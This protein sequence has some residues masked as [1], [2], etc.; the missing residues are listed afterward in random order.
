MNARVITGIALLVVTRL[1]GAQCPPPHLNPQDT[2]ATARITYRAVSTS[3]VVG[4]P[5]VGASNAS[6]VVGNAGEPALTTHVPDHIVDLRLGYDDQRS[7][8]VTSA[9]R[10]PQSRDAIAIGGYGRVRSMHMIR[11]GLVADDGGCRQFVAS[12]DNRVSGHPIVD[13]QSAGSV[14]QG[15]TVRSEDDLRRLGTVSRLADGRLHVRSVVQDRARPDDLQG[16]IL[17][18]YRRSGRSF[19]I[20]RAEIA[21]ESRAIREDG[22]VAVLRNSSIHEFDGV[23]VVIPDS[24]AEHRRLTAAIPQRSLILTAPVS[25]APDVR[26]L[27]RDASQPGAFLPSQNDGGSQNVVFQH[28][29]LANG[30]TWARME[31]WL[32]GDFAFG[33]KLLPSLRSTDRLGAQRDALVQRITE[34]GARDWILIGHSNGGLVSRSAAQQIPGLVRGVITSSSLHNGAI[35]V[36][37]GRE[38][39]ARRL[40]EL[41]GTLGNLAAVLQMPLLGG[42]LSSFAFDSLLPVTRDMSPSSAFIRQLNASDE[43]FLR[44]SI[45]NISD[46]RWVAFRVVGDSR[47][48][49]ESGCGGRAWVRYVNSIYMAL[50]SC[51]PVSLSLGFLDPGNA[52]T[53]QQTAARCSHLAGALDTLD[54]Y[55]NKLYSANTGGDGVVDSGAQ[56]WRG[57]LAVRI[58]DA[59]SH[60]G[61][62]RSDKV[63]D[64]LARVLDQQFQVPRRS[65]VSL[66]SAASFGR[67]GVAPGSIVSLFGSQL[68]ERTEQASAVPLPTA[69]AGAT[70]ELRDA[71]G[72]TRPLELFFV[73]PTQINAAI[74]SDVA[75]GPAS[76]RVRTPGGLI[77]SG[78]LSVTRVAPGLFT[79]DGSGAGMASGYVVRSRPGGGSTNEAIAERDAATG[80]FR[81]LPIELG[82]S[83]DTVHLILYGTGFRGYTGA[84]NVL[85]QIGD[86]AV[87]V[88]YA[89]RVE[90]NV[91]LDQINLRLPRELAG[92][93]ELSVVLTVDGRAANE[94]RVA[95]R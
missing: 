78:V 84:A 79:A 86:T 33:T 6:R 61:V 21:T 12:P 20:E 2:S 38:A 47:C 4:Q 39:A 56:V 1:A 19:V 66:V 49:P 93:G 3:G 57:A 59:D 83:G 42:T 11:G 94:V 14:M 72:V 95:I 90:R 44:V 30:G 62:N 58:A 5:G 8:V 87:P 35:I 80:R 18:T 89:G 64:A 60:T 43:R 46:P 71:A 13:L 77:R 24:M 27:A 81:P 53:Y 73:S 41:A 25:P 82:G 67:D 15:L 65:G 31:P 32:S 40:E 51:V 91:G 37:S 9:V 45:E 48:D 10:S 7:L 34:S 74:P 55:W 54:A 23:T 22:Q 50:R 68:A 17:M 92:R 88:E 26:P 70:V 69:L 76:F 16:E 36:Q 29:F 63:R 75:V 85:A 28:G 52:A